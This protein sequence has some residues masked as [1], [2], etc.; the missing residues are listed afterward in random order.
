MRTP[1]S[2]MNPI[3]ITV[4]I[5]LG[6]S[7]IYAFIKFSPFMGQ[8]AKVEIAMTQNSDGVKAEKGMMVSVHYLGR[9]Q[10][11]TVFDDSFKRGEPISFVLGNGMVI[12]GWEQGIEGMIVGEKRTLTIPPELGY[13]EAGAGDVIPPNATL[14]FD[15]ELVEAVIPPTLS[16]VSPDELEKLIKSGVTVIDIRRPDEWEDIGLIEGAI[17]IQSFTQQGQVHPEFLEKFNQAVPSKDT[18][19]VIYCHAASRSNQIG[20]ALVE[21]LG[22]SKAS[23]LAGG[24]MAWTESGRATTP[25]KN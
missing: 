6:M 15:V 12:Q 19:F 13:G 2:K 17:P 16:E 23:H 4:I 7:L 1:P 10:D 20:R 22:F 25:H 14:I 18:A 5:L 8:Q 9:L 21:Q 24:I 3:L 11:G